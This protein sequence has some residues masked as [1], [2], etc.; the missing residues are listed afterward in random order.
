MTNFLGVISYWA[1]AFAAVVIVEHV[2]IRRNDFSTYELGIW[3]KARRLPTG[4]AGLA[5]CA[6]ACGLVV[7]SIDQV[8]F[9]G[10]FAKT[11]GDIGFEMAFASTA[12]FYI[13]LRYIEV[14]YRGL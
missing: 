2:V 5:A 8:W 6:L 3:N 1:S 14:R 10:P 7:P 9:V 13:P 11:T 12:V 4:V